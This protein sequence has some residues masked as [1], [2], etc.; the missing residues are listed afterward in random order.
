[1]A[2]GGVSLESDNEESYL[3]D[4][5]K[6]EVSP[7][8]FLSFDDLEHDYKKLVNL[9]ELVSNK[10]KS[11]KLENKSLR[12]ELE[13]QKSL[14][15]DLAKNTHKGKLI[16]CLSCEDYELKIENLTS[17][18]D[19]LEKQAKIHKSEESLNN[20]LNCQR[21]SHNK[22]GLGYT[23]DKEQKSNNLSKHII[24]VKPLENVNSSTKV[25]KGLENLS[26]MPKNVES[27]KV[28]NKFYSQK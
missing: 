6:D 4:Q 15:D 20:M 11:L 26:K 17:K 12:D 3:K 25:N 27:P 14:V 5:C 28:I 21:S 16:A 22:S 23:Q 13:K 1:M 19:K 24:F 8:S 10:N 2:L 18:I 7:N 9:S